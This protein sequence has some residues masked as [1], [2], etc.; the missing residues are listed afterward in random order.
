MI[1]LV[2]RGVTVYTCQEHTLTE[3]RRERET[4]MEKR[5]RQHEREKEHRQHYAC[6]TGCRKLVHGSTGACANRTGVLYYTW[7][8][9]WRRRYSMRSRGETTTSASSSQHQRVCLQPGL[10]DRSNQGGIRA[11][12][13]H[14]HATGTGR[15]QI[16]APSALQAFS[17]LSL[18]L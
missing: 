6:Y 14:A 12:P 7:K 3:E 10:R 16:D 11:C 4:K 8:A 2:V 15:V 17:H 1:H 5:E 13:R 18:C 9:Q